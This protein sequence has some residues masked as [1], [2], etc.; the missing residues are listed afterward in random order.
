MDGIKK[1]YVFHRDLKKEYPI[2]THGEGVYL[3]DEGGKKYLD[4]CSGAVAA[5]LGHGI[6]S[7]GEAMAEQAKKAAF[8]HTMRFET[9][10]L[11]ELAEKIGEIAPERLNKVYFTTGGSEANESALKLARQYHRDGGKPQKHLVIGRWQSYHGNTIGSL[12]AGGDV[13]RRHVYTP[14]LLNYAHVYSPY[15]HR[16]PY[17]RQKDDCLAKQNWTCVTDIE[18]LILELGPENVSAFI[19]EAIVGSQQGAVPPPPG[20]FE[21]VRELCDRYDIVL[22]IDEVMTGFGRTGTNFATEQIGIEA[23]IITFGKGVSAGYAP[24]AG[25]IVHDRLIDGLIQNSDGKFVHG[26]T[27]SGHPVAV[28]AGLAALDVYERERVLENVKEQGGYL[29]DQLLE[30]KK[31]HS[32]ISDVRGR[33]LLIGIELVKDYDH[34]ELFDSSEK[35]ADTLNAIAM[36]LGAVFYPGTGSIDGTKGEHLIISPPLTV[37]KTEID[38]IVRILDESLI[39]FAGRLRKDETYEITK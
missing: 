22:I 28:A 20:Y 8:V 21:K 31:K 35:A 17:N 7:I 12:S 13:K 10:A 11:H 37:T 30:L 5:N 6:A 36:E 26:Y 27:Y 1:D 19:A 18:R 33:G 15:C 2:I 9:K 39:L 14:N 4:A 24:L 16:C 23:D 34:D 3:I 32:Y 38:E 25:M 29:F